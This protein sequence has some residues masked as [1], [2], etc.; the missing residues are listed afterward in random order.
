MGPGLGAA[1]LEPHLSGSCRSVPSTGWLLIC[2]TLKLLLCCTQ[3]GKN[4]TAAQLVGI[5]LNA[6][7]VQTLTLT[8]HCSCCCSLCVFADLSS[9]QHVLFAGCS[10]N[11]AW[12]Q[13][14]MS[15]LCS[16][17][18]QARLGNVIGHPGNSGKHAFHKQ[19]TVSM[20]A[21]SCTNQP[22]RQNCKHACLDQCI[23]LAELTVVNKLQLSSFTN[24]SGLLSL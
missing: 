5:N 19:D 15:E 4:A 9:D 11:S 7:H 20:A 24:P 18:P 12:Q 14:G 23:T 1:C 2:T 10:C 17:Q 13:A 22:D 8:V 21:F 3:P 16:R 6:Q